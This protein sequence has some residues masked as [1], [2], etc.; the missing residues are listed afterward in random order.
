MG[1]KGVKNLQIFDINFR[2]SPK[3]A[4]YLAEQKILMEVE[5]SIATT[6]ALC[7]GLFFLTTV[8]LLGSTVKE[9]QD[10]QTFKQK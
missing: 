8:S 2:W 7:S 4:M 5:E 10:F 1:G 6:S 9:Y 3:Q